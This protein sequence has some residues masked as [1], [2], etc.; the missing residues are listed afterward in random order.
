MLSPTPV[1][2]HLR[3]V[4]A[5]SH[6]DIEARLDAIA[7]LA[8]PAGRRDLLGCYYRMHAS[9]D[10]ALAPWLL[11]LAGLDAAAR[12]RTPILRRDL[13]ALGLPIPSLEGGPAVVVRNEFEALG[14][15]YVL[16][17]STLGG[18]MIHKALTTRGLGLVG[19][20][21]LDPYGAQTGSQWRSFL[22]VLERE[23]VA[24]I[25]AVGRGGAMGFAHAR[26]C[27]LDTVA[28]S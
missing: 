2:D 18:R 20:G 22:T 23:G 15:L 28:A 5:Q 27:L 9:A 14:F 17:G 11:A 10:A 3:A 26:L 8:S 4:T 6:A 25:Q 24:D 13:L 21:F 1:L 16:E 7:R 12:R 19:L